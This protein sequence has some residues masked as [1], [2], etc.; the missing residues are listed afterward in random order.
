[1]AFTLDDI[2]KFAAKPGSI[3]APGTYGEGQV[4]NIS[5]MLDT[6]KD[7]VKSGDLSLVE[8]Q[9]LTPG[10]VKQAQRSAMAAGGRGGSG[11]TWQ[12]IV[13]SGFAD[14]NGK[15]ANPFSNQE[16]AS[17]PDKVLPTQ[18]DINKGMFNP[19]GAP[20]QRVRSAP[21]PAVNPGTPGNTPATPAAPATPVTPAATAGN[22]S[23]TTPGAETPNHQ[24]GTAPVYTAS[25]DNP[26]PYGGLASTNAAGAYDAQRVAQEGALQQQL[27]TQNQEGITAKRQQYLNDLSGLLVQQQQQQMS[28]AAPG[29]YEDLNS[30]GLLR[31]SEL[32]NAMAREQRGL[33]AQT[34][35]QLAQYGIQGQ[36][37]DLGNYQTI[38]NNYNDSRNT[39]LNREFSI[40][41]Y[42]R[43]VATGKELGEQYANLKPAAVNSGKGA[44]IGTVVG[45]VGGAYLGGAP[46]AM[47]GSQI[48]GAAGGATQG[49]KNA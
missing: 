29:I 30:R 39:A 20:L 9:G 12:G 46:G 10:L 15:M 38:Q 21:Q 48:G 49:G 5:Q 26:P 37:A 42:N 47:A 44:Q 45:G 11:A 6:M 13:D 33:Q 7:A 14:G 3:P 24:T 35:N 18:E 19:T 43:Q 8:Y 22:N 27:S 32:G 17:L 1:M 16:Y 41:D 4:V 40:E 2:K 23:T 28:E 34:A 31:S 36:T 25:P